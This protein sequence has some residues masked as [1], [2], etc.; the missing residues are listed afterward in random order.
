LTVGI[1]AL[2]QSF[3][4]PARCLFFSKETTPYLKTN[5][6]RGDQNDWSRMVSKTELKQV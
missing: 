6:V 3:K 4:R 2:G 5:Q 1:L